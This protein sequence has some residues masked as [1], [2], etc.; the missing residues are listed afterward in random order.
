MRKKLQNI[1]NKYLAGV[2]TIAGILILW[3]IMYE[4]QVVP[5]FMLPSPVLVLKAFAAD[6]SLLMKHSVVTITEAVIGLGTSVFLGL[7][8]AVLM[9][10]VPIIYKAIYPL[11]IISQAVPVIAVAPLLVLWFGYGIAPKV[12]LIVSVCF[13]PI[14]VNLFDVFKNVDSD[15]INLL[16]SMGG[17]RVQQ[18]IHIK[19]PYA[20]PVFFSSLK[21]SI[22]YS[23]VGAVISEWLG[24][25]QGLG[26][27]M[28]RVR[29]SYSFD[30]MFAVIFLIVTISLVLIVITKIIEKRVL[31][32]KEM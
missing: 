3:Q 13:F 32:Y 27:Y 5:H 2:I 6:F 29:K 1:T 31:K 10:S 25:D 23:V 26:V 21:I 8:L 17:N 7:L 16:K 12:L 19:F 22:T 18:F 30:K 28:T 9:D 4:I 24:G 15:Q 14:A 11:I 20:L